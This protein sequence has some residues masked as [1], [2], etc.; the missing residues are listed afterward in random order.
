MTCGLNVVGDSAGE[1]FEKPAMDGGCLRE[2]QM[3]TRMYENELWVE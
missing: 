3:Q 1:P 2:T